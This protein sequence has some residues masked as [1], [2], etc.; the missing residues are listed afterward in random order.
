MSGGQ[1]AVIFSHLESAFD[2][3]SVIASL[4]RRVIGVHLSSP[5]YPP[6]YFVSERSYRLQLNALL[7]ES[8]LSNESKRLAKLTL[9]AC[10]VLLAYHD[11]I[12]SGSSLL[13]TEA[14]LREEYP[15]F[16]GTEEWAVLLIFRNYLAVSLLLM[17]AENNKA[18]HLTIAT[19]LSEGKQA[20][21]V[22]GSGQT[23]A[24]TRRVL[25]LEQESRRIRP[26]ILNS[27]GTFIG[28]PP[29]NGHHTAH[30][31]QDSQSA[32]ES[33]ELERYSNSSL[34]WELLDQH[35]LHCQG[36]GEQPPLHSGVAD[37]SVNAVFAALFDPTGSPPR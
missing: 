33:A 31:E 27:S 17:V 4:I 19:R 22:T 3:P 32:A 5:S 9:K 20:R 30:E 8:T 37:E 29:M 11:C 23:P 16:V 6:T 10:L 21:Y 13:Y 28:A 2:V 26:L 1:Q 24:T 36:V 7:R 15:G 12:T 18:K 34:N 25:I 35:Y 14:Q